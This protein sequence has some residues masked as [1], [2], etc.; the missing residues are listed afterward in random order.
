MSGLGGGVTDTRMRVLVC[1][2]RDYADAANVA[3]VLARIDAY[4][5]IVVL[6]HGGAPG[7]DRLAALWAMIHDI[8]VAEFLAD[9]RAHGRAAG[10]CAGGGM[11]HE[12]WPDLV[13]ALV[14]Y[15]GVWAMVAIVPHLSP[16]AFVATTA[17]TV[18]GLAAFVLSVR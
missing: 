17:W 5:R 12:G 3:T 10:E 1:G 6:I 18:V 14:S 11:T 2:G 4:Y 8:P 16:A 13:V 15:I 9:W 7:A